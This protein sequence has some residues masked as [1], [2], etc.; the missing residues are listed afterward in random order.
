MFLPVWQLSALPGYGPRVAEPT[1]WA[2]YLTL[3]P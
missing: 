1:R 3:G 2:L